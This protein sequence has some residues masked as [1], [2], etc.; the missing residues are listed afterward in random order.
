MH[1]REREER[2]GLGR[3][4]GG[5]KGI[6]PSAASH[7]L[8]RLDPPC[9][10]IVL[11]CTLY[12]T[13]NHLILQHNFSVLHCIPSYC[14]ILY[15]IALHCI[16]LHCPALQC[17]AKCS[18]GAFT[19]PG[20]SPSSCPCLLDVPIFMPWKFVELL[21]ILHLYLGLPLFLN[22]DHEHNVIRESSFELYCLLQKVPTID[23]QKES[24]RCSFF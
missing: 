6:K 12:F 11:H 4:K 18:Q 24:Q 20:S 2:V 3:G 1:R 14:I 22:F 17:K 5:C 15:C 13:D 23:I 10:A 16:S 7:P 21:L 9:I 19:M 8:L